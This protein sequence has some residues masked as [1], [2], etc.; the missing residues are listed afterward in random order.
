M[1][2]VDRKFQIQA[3]NP[4][5]GKRYT[6]ADSLLLC[7]K[8]KAVP[9]A[10][11]AYKL[12]CEKIGAN[13]EHVRSIELLYNRVKDFQAVMGGGRVPDTVGE[14]IPRCLNGEGVD[15][16][17]AILSQPLYSRRK[18]EAE[19]AALKDQNLRILRKEFAQICSYCGHEFPADGAQWKDLQAHIQVCPQH[20]VGKLNAALH[21]AKEALDQLA[22]L[23]NGN[24]F[25]NSVGN[26]IAQDALVELDNMRKAA[27]PAPQNE[28][29]TCT[30]NEPDSLCQLHTF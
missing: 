12:E 1:E 22:R 13:P 24:K 9:A 7:A 4:V 2:V 27:E 20:P 23:G 30:C 6:E 14:E 26:C 25:G 21:V 8:D 3:I 29:L 18:L 15:E 17:S 28:P 19:N 16:E 10:I 11:F 5:N